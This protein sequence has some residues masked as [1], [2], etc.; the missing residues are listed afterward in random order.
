MLNL[1]YTSFW[2]LANFLILILVFCLSLISF[3]SFFDNQDFNF[4]WFYG[5]DKFL[6]LITFMFLSVWLSGQFRKNSYWKPAIFLLIFG[7]FIEIIQHKI[8]YRT[9]DLYDLFANTLGVIFGFLIGLAG[10]GGWCLRAESQIT[11]NLSD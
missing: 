11:R 8:N 5:V 2:L 1:R 3:P 10:L 9:A 4:L 7:L 6:H